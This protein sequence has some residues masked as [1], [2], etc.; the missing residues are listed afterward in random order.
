M[1][2]PPIDA[3]GYRARIS[4][5]LPASNT[6]GEPEFAM[7]KPIGVTNQTFR[8]APTP[9]AKS[10]TV[11]NL[12]TYAGSV[13]EKIQ[14]FEDAINVALQA[15]PKVILLAYSMDTFRG[16]VAGAKAMEDGLKA[17][18][19]GVPVIVP[20]LAYLDA[21][22]VLGLKPGATIAGL[23]PY[24]PKEDE[25]VRNFFVDAGYK[26]TRVHGFKCNGGAEIAAVT[27]PQIIDAL[28]GLAAD[29]PQA[30]VLPGTNMASMKV[31]DQ[32]A[33][34]L[35]IPVLCCNTVCYWSA[36]RAAGITDRM[37]GFGPLLAW[38]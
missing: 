12:E 20:A 6:I 18:A 10:A 13:K 37:S 30:I 26:V 16:G 31:A 8:L 32:A 15:T 23:T 5:L 28:R 7:L 11:G 1:D 36:L 17:A 9:P 2:M 35:G 19:K 22:N 14:P 4:I 29:K 33:A 21:L 25:E 38:H 34:W 3:L 24:H 27:E